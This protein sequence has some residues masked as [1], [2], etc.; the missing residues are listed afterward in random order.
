MKLK[1]WLEI[2]TKQIKHNIK[3]RS[4]NSYRDIIN[5]HICPQ[6]G[7]Y[8]LEQLSPKILQQFVFYL[9]ENGNNKTHGPLSPN[10]VILIVTILK[11]AIKDANLYEITSKNYTNLV[12][13]PSVDYGHVS[14]FE[15]WEQQKIEKYCLENKKNYVGIIICLYTGLR[16]G[17]L[18]ALTW[19]DIDFENNIMCISKSAYQTK[20]NGKIKIIVDT[21]KTKTSNRIIPISKQLA[22]ILKKNKKNSTSKFVI[23]TKNSTMVGTRSYQKTFEYMLKK[24]NIAK[25]N[26]HS[27]RHTFATRALEFG[28]DVKTVSEILGHK[29]AMITLKRYTHSLMS[30]KRTMMNKFGKLLNCNMQF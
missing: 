14:A 18:L 26:F 10:S 20:V 16:I 30:H 19:K 7:E 9:Q 5:N 4:F 12:K 23:S 11:Q 27:L 25:K 1:N 22:A 3:Q 21:P 15:K 2:W 29:D 13:L 28:I 6:L 24:L 8:E 17:E